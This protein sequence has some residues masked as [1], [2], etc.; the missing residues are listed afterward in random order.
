MLNS[1]ARR[2]D[3]A[4][5]RGMSAKLGLP[6]PDRDLVSDTLGLLREQRVD[7]TTFFRALAA[8]TAADL[9]ADPAPFEE[10]ARR[11]EA[12]LP[13]DRAE[14]TAAMNRLNPV[15]IP[16]NHRV[17]QAIDAGV[18]GDFA[19][20]HRLVEAVTH[21]FEDRDDWAELALSPAQGEEVRVTYCGT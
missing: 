4:A 18:Q 19:P 2:Y 5:A 20:F 6:E 17:Q 14:V 16:R 7:L 21:P 11:R 3:E 13:A 15:Y 8:G 12:V 10:W 1:F 9:F